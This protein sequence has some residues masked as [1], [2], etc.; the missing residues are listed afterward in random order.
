[1]TLTGTLTSA[2]ELTWGNTTAPIKL[3]CNLPKKVIRRRV[4]ITGTLA[5][6]SKRAYIKVE[7]V[8]PATGLDTRD[9]NITGY[10]RR[11]DPERINSRGRRSARL[12]LY[13]EKD[14]PET[15]VLV[16]VL[17]SKID[18]LGFDNLSIGQQISLCG[19]IA[20]H[21]RGFHLVFMRALGEGGNGQ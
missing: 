20:Y 2:T 19:Q 9:V 18:E 16:T 8:V 3:T 6:N 14:N 12:H 21:V 15:A 4:T 5:Y 1:M 13:Q 11:I 7:N 10:I 17:D